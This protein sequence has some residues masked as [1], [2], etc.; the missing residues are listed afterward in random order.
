VVLPSC[1]APRPS[2]TLA[3]LA[4]T[5]GR[6]LSRL[7]REHTGMNLPD[8][9]NRLRVALAHELLAQTRLDIERVAERAGVRLGASASADVAKWY[10]TP[11]RASRDEAA[12]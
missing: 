8:D 3:K 6:H 4:G 7:F 10:P 2:A 1:V 11:P 12:V 5:S 9:R